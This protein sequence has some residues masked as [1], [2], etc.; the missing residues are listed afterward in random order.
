MPRAR[1]LILLLTFLIAPLPGRA[2]TRSVGPDLA[3][4]RPSEASRAARPGDRI[5]IAPGTYRDCAIW[6]VPDLTI[7][8]APGG[9]VEI[10]GP[11]CAGKGLFVT[12]APRITI[13]GLTFRGAR[14]AAGNGAGI[15]AEGGDLTIR[16]ARFID[17]QNGILTASNAR[18]TLLIDSSEFIGN[19]A[20]EK[21]CAHGLYAGRLAAVVILNS[22]FTDTRICHHV[23]SRAART[24]I[25]GTTILDGADTAT[26]YLVDI[27]NGGDLLLS[28]STLRKGP[29][30]DNPQAAVVIGAEG[31]S[32]PTTRIEIRD[33]RFSN[34]MPRRTIFVRN[35]TRTAATLAGNR[36]NGAV[37]PLQGPGTVR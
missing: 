34:R 36:L 12:A 24:E 19:G 35:L 14:A 3:Y 32:H 6:R 27:P 28:G 13:T 11:V 22:R 20:L 16:R 9:A 26:S 33:N 37:L 2:E 4:A 5:V 7:E 17:N 10:T 29:R 30:S 15:R 25:I 23:K 31:V 8:A 1:S 18:A 21:E